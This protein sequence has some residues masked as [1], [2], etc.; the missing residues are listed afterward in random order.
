MIGLS[1]NKTF[2]ESGNKFFCLYLIFVVVYLGAQMF[3]GLSYLDI[4]MYMSGYQYFNEDPYASYF[5]GQWILTYNLTS[6]LCKVFSID[7]YIG[8]RVMHLV[9]VLVSQ[10]IVYFYLKRYISKRSIIVGL[11]VTTLAHYGS[12]TE[13]NYNDYS[14]VLLLLSILSFHC[15]SN[16]NKAWL[17][18]LSGVI[19]G[20]S[21]FFRIVNITFIGIPLLSLLI[22]L[23]W[24]VKM[25]PVRRVVFFY[26]GV[27]VGI[28]GTLAILKVQNLLDVF[29]LTFADIFIISADNGDP[30][31]LLFVMRSLYNLYSNLLANA[32]YITLLWLMIRQTME[33]QRSL[34]RLTMFGVIVI[35]T[36]VIM[37][38][39]YFPSNITMA[40]CI[41]GSVAL[42]FAYYKVETSLAHL[43]LL[44]LYL[45]LILPFGSNA[46]PSFYGKEICFL[47]LPLSVY[48]LFD[49][50]TKC[51]EQKQ[52][53]LRALLYKSSAGFLLAV[54]SVGFIFYN[55]T[56]KQMEE[57]N[58]LSCRYMVNNSRTCYIL[59]TGENASMYNHLVNELST[60]VPKES[61]MICSFSLPM[62][63]ILECRP[64]AVYSTVYSTDKMNDRYI[65]VA[66]K[67]T[68]KLPYV[69]LDDED[70]ST[71][72]KH[73]LDK[74]SLIKSYRK[75]WTDG[76]YSLYYY[77]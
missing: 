61:Y 65:D 52:N 54:L 68:G 77:K 13:I 74:L 38:F 27:L 5:L 29:A 50:L 48:V 26:M 59:T 25:K 34:V 6:A 53:E 21:I 7:S 3:Q 66:W 46:E 33:I 55:I 67:H 40:I 73:I 14:A 24:D 56:H 64:W 10:M 47:T 16:K 44:S 8:L 19:V 57:G 17:I 41:I 39:S 36:F 62:V 72:Y 69:L 63:S 20:I 70:L 45:P 35:L 4:G 42:F 51:L 1:E 58:R 49:A 71:G 76:K 43:I 11:F 2:F 60:Y 32:V 12:Y 30:H 15:G 37:H 22:S 9:Y 18:V 23:K 75:V 28:I 31:G